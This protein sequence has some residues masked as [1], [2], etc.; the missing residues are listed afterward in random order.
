MEPLRVTTRLLISEKEF[1][2]ST[3]RSSGPGGQNVNK[4]NTKATLRWS[5]SKCEQMP[6]AWK[7]RFLESYRTRITREGEIVLHSDRYRDQKK[8]IHD[9]RQRLVRMLLGCQHPPKKRT[10]TVPTKG[11]QRRRLQNKR[12]HSEKK[13]RRQGKPGLD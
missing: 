7:Q 2:I 9:V 8:N 11:S 5:P 10:P 1:Q 12:E 6:A 3:A 13:A 4:L